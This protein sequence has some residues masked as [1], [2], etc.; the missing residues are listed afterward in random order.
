MAQHYTE[1]NPF[2][3]KR[4]NPAI[5]AD[6]FGRADVVGDEPRT[7]L[8]GLRCAN[9]PYVIPRSIPRSIPGPATWRARSLLFF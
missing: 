3:G 5:R 1:L 6:R 7:A 9:P 8:G 2:W 4:P